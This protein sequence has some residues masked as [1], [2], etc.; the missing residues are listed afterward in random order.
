MGGRVEEREERKGREGKRRKEIGYEIHFFV[1]LNL[2]L[3]ET[4]F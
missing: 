1:A 2:S 3:L 4:I